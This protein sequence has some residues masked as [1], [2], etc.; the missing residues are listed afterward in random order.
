MTASESSED[1]A[2][3]PIFFPSVLY[4]VLCKKG[5]L[6]EQL[7]MSTDLT[8]DSFLD[9]NLR[10]SFNEHKQFILNAIQVTG[11]SH[12]GWWFGQQLNVSS[13]G[14]LGYAAMSCD[15]V[16]EALQTIAKYFKLRAPLYSLKLLTSID[17]ADASLK[18]KSA[19]QIDSNIDFAEIEYFLLSSA[20]SGA[21]NLLSY[22]SSKGGTG[23]GNESQDNIVERVELTVPQPEDWEVAYSAMSCTVVF[24]ALYNRL[25][26]SSDVLKKESVAADPATKNAINALCKKQ[27]S[28]LE[29]QHILAVKVRQFIL[30][31]EGKFPSLDEAAAHFFMSPRTLRRE[32]QKEHTTYQTLLDKVRENIAIKYLTTTNKPINQIAYDVGF[33]DKSNFG[34]AFKRWTGKRPSDFRV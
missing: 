32:L 31:Q 13:L 20:L 4:R 8:S 28:E 16:E 26:F 29:R 14:L 19:L 22:Y 11:N 17:T 24:G 1:E 25:I 6:S 5:I 2:I 21:A 27:L 10:I 15:L 7:L 9:E 30:Q 3:L 12:L 23:E 33:A 34:R 18:D